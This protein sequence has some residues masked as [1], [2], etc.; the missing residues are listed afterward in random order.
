MSKERNGPHSPLGPEEWG[1]GEASIT[2]EEALTLCGGFGP[3]QYYVSVVLILAFLTKGW[4]VYGLPYLET[5][6]D[7]EILFDNN[8]I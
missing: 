2:Y 5:A 7:Y 6:P 3:S 4:I 8:W 1:E